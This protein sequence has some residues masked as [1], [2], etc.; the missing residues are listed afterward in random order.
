MD[1]WLLT[2]NLWLS[3]QVYV[4]GV[5][6][7]LLKSHEQSVC[8]CTS[9]KPGVPSVLPASSQLKGLAWV[10]ASLIYEQPRSGE[11]EEARKVS[12]KGIPG[13][14]EWPA[15][16]SGVLGRSDIKP[17]RQGCCGQCTGDFCPTPATLDWKAWASL[18]RWVSRRDDGKRESYIA[19]AN[20]TSPSTRILNSSLCPVGC[21][22]LESG[23]EAFAW[24]SNL[25]VIL[26]LLEKGD[27]AAQLLEIWLQRY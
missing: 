27:I 23:K 4:L 9:A 17:A 25:N 12:A 18:R 26:G 3:E 22:C 20:R 7:L 11:L 13:S 8:T 16:C 6:H 21:P 24:L 15:E 2:S 19:V 14:Q 1:I 5:W 10:A